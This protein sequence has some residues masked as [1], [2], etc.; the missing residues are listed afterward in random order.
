[1]TQKKIKKDIK[2]TNI[3][4]KIEIDLNFQFGK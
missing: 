2:N 4:A 1:M 3:T